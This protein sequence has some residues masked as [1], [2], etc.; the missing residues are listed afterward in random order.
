MGSMAPDPTH[1]DRLRTW[2]V[3][4][5][6]TKS[7]ADL[8]PNAAATL[9]RRQQQ[10]GNF[11]QA[12]DT[13]VPAAMRDQ[14]RVESMRGG[15]AK[16]IAESASVRFQLDRALRSGLLSQLRAACP[17]ALTRVDVRSGAV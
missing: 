6:R 11:A 15:I 12:W 5:A 17:V 4:P 13:C 10:T 3:R 14:C 2:R 8:V 7:L 9:E 1:L 16:V